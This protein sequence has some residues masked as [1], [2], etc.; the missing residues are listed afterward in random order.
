MGLPKTQNSIRAIPI[1]NKL[2]DILKKHKKKYKDEDYFLSGES[3]RFIEPRNYEKYY[4]QILKKCRIKAY[5]F[6][7]CRHYF[8]SHCIE[9]G[10]DIKSLSEILG[11]SS[12]EVTLEKYV[13][14]NLK[15]QKKYLEKI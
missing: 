1:S 13:H 15:T 4:K 9:V 14:S 3:E 12:I 10:M 6:H 7:T 11:H 8:S 5:K 2:Y